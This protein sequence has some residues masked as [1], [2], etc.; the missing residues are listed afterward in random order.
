M[1]WRR[2][3]RFSTAPR[4][5]MVILS[6]TGEGGISARRGV[7]ICAQPQSHAITMHNHPASRGTPFFRI[8]SLRDSA[9]AKGSAPGIKHQRGRALHSSETPCR[10]GAQPRLP[11][12]SKMK[13]RLHPFLNIRNERRIS[14]NQTAGKNDRLRIE[15]IE[16]VGDSFR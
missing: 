10:C 1:V 15:Q 4:M 12:F 8:S 14:F 2:S 11:L 9:G 5:S 16:K 6:V 3:E 7:A 13:K